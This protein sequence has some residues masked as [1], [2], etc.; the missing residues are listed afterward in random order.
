MV[1]DVFEQQQKTINTLYQCVNIT[2]W[3]QR[4]N[5]TNQSGVERMKKDDTFS[6]LWSDMIFIFPSRENISE[7]SFPI[8][9][10]KTV[11][12]SSR[13]LLFNFVRVGAIRIMNWISNS[14]SNDNN[15]NNHIWWRLLLMINYYTEGFFM[16]SEGISRDHINCRELN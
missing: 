15:S 2:S 1:G 6:T 14:T 7:N 12:K 10:Q 8:E 4:Q 16:S 3:N 5:E 9:L 13:E 11:S